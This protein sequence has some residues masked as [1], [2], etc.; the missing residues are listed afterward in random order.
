M[1]K[2]MIRKWL[3]VPSEEEIKEVRLAMRNEVASRRR[4][5]T[6]APSPEET[7]SAIKKIKEQYSTGEVIPAYDSRFA[8]SIIDIPKLPG[9]IVYHA[10]LPGTEDYF[11]MA[12]VG[13]RC[14]HV[15]D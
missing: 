8:C 9:V 1:L 2:N 13:W 14:I 4:C 3:G 5:N 10:N 6:C 12:L 7:A 15:G 11:C